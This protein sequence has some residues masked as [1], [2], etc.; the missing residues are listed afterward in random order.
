MGKKHKKKSGQQLLAD[1]R[2]TRSLSKAKEKFQRN[3]ENATEGLM[4]FETDDYVSQRSPGQPYTVFLARYFMRFAN[5]N[6]QGKEFKGQREFDNLMRVF[7]QA[8]SSSSSDVKIQKP[9]RSKI[10][11]LA[12]DCYETLAP[13]STE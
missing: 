7:K 2:F 6:K 5:K 10:E 11:Q 9:T 8:R 12:E 3:F 4:Q 13:G 1:K